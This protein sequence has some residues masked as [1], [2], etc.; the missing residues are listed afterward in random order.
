MPD[1]LLDSFRSRLAR[2]LAPLCGPRSIAAVVE[3]RDRTAG[4]AD[5]G[6]LAEEAGLLNLAFRE[7]QL[8]LRDEPDHPVA[9]FRLAH[10]YRERGEPGRA[11]DLLER[12]LAKEPVRDDWL[13][14]LVGVLH[15]D[16]AAP[17][18][19]P[20]LIARRRRRAAGHSRRRP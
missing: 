13:A 15:D 14:L 4:H 12:L 2:R 20:R 17:R 11:A 9:A 1:P 6:L 19:A 10:H 7:F 5:W 18:T 3:R 8:A 16:N